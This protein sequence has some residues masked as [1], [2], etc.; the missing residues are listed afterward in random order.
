MRK[1]ATIL[2]ALVV[3]AAPAAGFSPTVAVLA[4]LGVGIVGG[5]AGTAVAVSVVGQV[6]PT[7]DSRAARI[8]AVI[9]SLTIFA[10]LGGSAGVLAAGRLFGVSGNVRA[11]LIGGVAGGLLSAFVEPILYRL[12]VPAGITEFFGFILMPTLPAIGGTIGHNR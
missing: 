3:F 10:G 7:F 4:E 6:T 9:V 11:C 2:F 8:A 5:V 1:P 12:G